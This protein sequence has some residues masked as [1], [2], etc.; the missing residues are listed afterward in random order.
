MN[1]NATGR[2]TSFLQQAKGLREAADEG[3]AMDREAWGEPLSNSENTLVPGGPPGRP[4]YGRGDTTGKGGAGLGGEALGG[5]RQRPKAVGTPVEVRR[6][7]QQAAR[8]VRRHRGMFSYNGQVPPFLTTA[9]LMDDTKRLASML[10]ADTSAIIGVAR[11]GLCPATMASMLLHRPLMVFRQNSSDIID[12]GNGWRLTGNTTTKGPVVVV[13]DTCMTGNSLKHVMPLVRQRFPGA[14]SA[15]VYCN[16]TAKTRPDLFARELPWPHVLEWN[17]FNSILTPQ[18][19]TDFD[20]I[21]CEECPPGSDDDGPRY[22]RFLQQARP[23][24]LTRRV[25]IPLVVTARLEKY[26]PQTLE[27]LNR[28]GVAVDRLVMGPWSSVRERTIENVVRF[29]AD[30]YTAF[31]KRRHALMPPLFIESCPHQAQRIAQRAR[32]LVACP[33]AGKV[34]R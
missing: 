21:L 16:P 4:W 18:C 32:G 12:G 3:T 28:H 10:P 5:G 25:P 27:W 33:A 2:P 24:Y 11:S 13:D 17:L 19:A 22:L 14:I 6:S 30:Q 23:L 1:P 31:L 8:M 26:R 9:S 29:K 20:G 15:T 7:V 34:F